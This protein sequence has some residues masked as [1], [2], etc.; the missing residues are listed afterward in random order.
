MCL[1]YS[2]VCFNDLL[3]GQARGAEGTRMLAY[4]F[5][6]TSGARGPIVIVRIFR[7]LSP[8]G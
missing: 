1:V 5:P 6:R 7:G 8:R 4:A 3:G 2:F